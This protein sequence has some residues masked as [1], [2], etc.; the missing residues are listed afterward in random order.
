M[1]CL[2]APGTGRYA[3][4]LWLW[5]WVSARLLLGVAGTV[6]TDRERWHR[7]ECKYPR[8]IAGVLT[9]FHKLC[10]NLPLS[11]SSIVLARVSAA[12]RAIPTLHVWLLGPS[13]G[14]TVTC[15]ATRFRHCA[16][17]GSDARC[18][19]PFSFRALNISVVEYCVLTH[20]PACDIICNATRRKPIIE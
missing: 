14:W 15:G 2:L 8:R 7:P 18:C 20:E 4:A 1:C 17:E 3:E 11:H 5:R 6:G 10:S 9:P 16:A 13:T 19:V 12:G